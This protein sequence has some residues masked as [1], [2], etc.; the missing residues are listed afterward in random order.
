M[1]PNYHR[2]LG[3]EMTSVSAA[4]PESLAYSLDFL[5]WR[6]GQQDAK[7]LFDRYTVLLELVIGGEAGCERRSE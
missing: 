6:L 4:K 3:E 2:K 5:R 1:P 7:P